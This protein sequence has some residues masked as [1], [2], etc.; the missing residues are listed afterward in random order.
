MAQY[1]T[2]ANASD[3]WTCDVTAADTDSR[4][5]ACP[6]WRA[7]LTAGEPFPTFA[8]AQLRVPATQCVLICVFSSTV[9]ED[10]E[11]VSRSAAMPGFYACAHGRADAA[12]RQQQAEHLPDLRPEAG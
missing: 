4:E 7:G 2:T 8:V 5:E 12:G 3:L 1:V 9:H 6:A 10:A 11:E